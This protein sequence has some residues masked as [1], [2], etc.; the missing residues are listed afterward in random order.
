MSGDEDL[1][2][3]PDWG[4]APQRLT[5]FRTRLNAADLKRMEIYV[6]KDVQATIREISK[7]ESTSAGVAAEALLA[8][9]IRAYLVGKGYVPAAQPDGTHQD[10]RM[11]R[12]KILA[13]APLKAYSARY[14]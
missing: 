2:R 7:V 8:L 1:S 5:R 6:L 10:T 4:A 3:S 12:L 14:G 13:D 9:G 11:D